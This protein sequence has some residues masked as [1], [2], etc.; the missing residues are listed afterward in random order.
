MLSEDKSTKENGQA[1]EMS[2]KEESLNTKENSKEEEPNDGPR[3]PRCN[4]VGYIGAC[5]VC[6]DGNGFNIRD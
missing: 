3:C 4:A 6:G 1:K 5:Y 2:T